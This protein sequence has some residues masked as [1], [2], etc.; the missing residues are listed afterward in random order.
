L[1]ADGEVMSIDVDPQPMPRA[2]SA[3]AANS[4]ACMRQSSVQTPRREQKSED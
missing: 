1:L 4:R 2:A 3:H